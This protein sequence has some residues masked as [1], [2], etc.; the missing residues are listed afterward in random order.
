MLFFDCP[1]VLQ[2]LVDASYYQGLEEKFSE[3]SLFEFR[4]KNLAKIMG[5][6]INNFIH[7]IYQVSVIFMAV[8]RCHGVAIKDS[9][10]HLAFILLF[11]S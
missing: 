9:V 4:E 5:L 8:S 3:A 2:A 11:N 6:A 7:E 10:S 1:I